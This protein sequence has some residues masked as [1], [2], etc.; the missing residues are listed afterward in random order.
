VVLG[1]FFAGIVGSNP[2]VGMTVFCAC[3]VVR[4]MALQ[5]AYDSYSGIIP[6]VCVCVCV[7]E[8]DKAQPA[9]H[10]SNHLDVTFSII[11]T[12]FLQLY[13]FRAFLAHLQE[14]ICCTG[15][16]WLDK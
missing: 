6:C 12:L 11:S 13:T 3:Y 5:R 8:C 14:L 2:S 7:I 1:R 16:C 10:I 4:Q 9:I 15:S